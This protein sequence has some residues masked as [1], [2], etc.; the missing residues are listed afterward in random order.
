MPPYQVAAFIKAAFEEGF[1]HASEDA[2]PKEFW[3][4]STA[5]VVCDGLLSAPCAT[6]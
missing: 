6:G 4:E 2:D 1:S 3:N 5:K